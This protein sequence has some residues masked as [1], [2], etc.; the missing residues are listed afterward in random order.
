MGFLMMYE[1][2]NK[3]IKER[4]A[5]L[6][7]L[8]LNDNDRVLD[9]GCG[10]GLMLIGA[11]KRLITGKAIGIDIWVSKDQSQNTMQAT[12][13][14]AQKEGV[15][16]RVEVKTA[17]MR[18]LPFENASFDVIVSHWVVHNLEQ[19]LDRDKALSEMVR[20][21]KPNGRLSLTDIENRLEYV[22]RLTALGLS[23]I[24][25]VSNPLRDFILGLVS[26]GSFKPGT[27][28]AIKPN[29]GNV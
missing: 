11:A 4:D 17:D 14:N 21:L 22:E 3:K 10:R 19:K 16:D 18:S 2:K 25:I 28:F 24:F 29:L 15:A 26:F 9:V 1:S 27:V 5:I 6:D 7:Q 8:Q 20:V 23:N 12:L 13:D